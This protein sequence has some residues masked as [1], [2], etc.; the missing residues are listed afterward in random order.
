[1]DTPGIHE[2][3][4]SDLRRAE[5]T[6][7]YPDIAGVERDCRFGDCS[8]THE[9]GCAVKAAMQQGR[10]SNTRYHSYTRIYRSL[11]A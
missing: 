5:L 7:F 9:P 8:H 10:L 3:G 4:L 2:F 1:M 6:R 11:P